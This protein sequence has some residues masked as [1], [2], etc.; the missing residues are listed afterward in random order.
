MKNRNILKTFAVQSA[1]QLS[2]KHTKP[3]KQSRRRWH[4]HVRGATKGRLLASETGNAEYVGSMDTATA[5]AY[6]NGG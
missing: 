3:A 1:R 2:I 4:V 5:D 6:G